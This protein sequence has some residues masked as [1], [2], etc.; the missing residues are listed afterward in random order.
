MFL[1][2]WDA[3]RLTSPPHSQAPQVCKACQWGLWSPPQVHP[4]SLAAL[5]ALRK[6]KP[7]LQLSC[8]PHCCSPP[9]SGGGIW[10]SRSSQQLQIPNFFACSPNTCPATQMGKMHLQPMT[11]ASSHPALIGSHC[12]LNLFHLGILGHKYT[13]SVFLCCFWDWT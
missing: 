13:L 1:F 6:H 11:W 5:W 9:R 8:P 3:S 4:G 12:F 7:P 10:R 2:R